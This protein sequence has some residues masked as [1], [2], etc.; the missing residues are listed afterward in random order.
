MGKKIRIHIRDK[1]TR[2]IFPYFWG[3]KI[4]KFFEAD[5]G[6]KKLGS[7]M[8]KNTDPRSGIEKIRIRDKHP[9]SATMDISFLLSHELQ[10]RNSLTRIRLYR[11]VRTF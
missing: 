1:Q 3:F 10:K 9:G 2:I 8:E 6:W 4:L 5:P 11:D 7:G